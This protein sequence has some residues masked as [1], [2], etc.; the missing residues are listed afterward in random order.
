MVRLY[1]VALVAVAL[2]ACQ[3]DL[4][5][6]PWPPTWPW[7]AAPTA[8]PQVSALSILGP[9]GRAAENQHIQDQ[10]AAFERANPGLRLSGALTPDY[11]TALADAVAAHTPPD[12]FVVWS[13][14]LADLAADD[15]V[16]PIPP[17][18]DRTA[19]LPDPLRPA[20]QV[21]GVP[22]CLPRDLST[23]ALFF[24]PAL[25]DRAEAAYPT[26]L[27]TWDDLRRAATATTDANN[28]IYGLT[29]APDASRLLAWLA[30]DD[31][32]GDPWRGADAVSTLNNYVNLFAEGAAVDPLLLDSTWTGEAFGRGRAAMTLEANWLIPYLAEQ[33]PDLVYNIVELPSGTSRRSTVAFG[34]CWAISRT[35]AD[36]QAALR[37]AAFLT[38]PDAN[39][40]WA[41]AAGALPPAPDQGRAWLTGQPA[42]APFVAGLDY[43]LPWAGPRGFSTTMDSLNS[44]LAAAAI[45]DATAADVVARLDPS[46]TP[47]PTHTTPE[48]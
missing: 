30:A 27:W 37:L 22:Y 29:L 8:T 4:P 41:T 35:A 42:Y 32:D 17:A 46:A 20:F 25:F 6:P 19:S 11:R 18:Y 48:D 12:L 43:A 16:R 40:G 7:R 2:T 24:N 5:S 44:L 39:R 36:P 3:G 23:L 26:P 33:F 28:G 14:E 15:I 21:D 1:L 47:A 13:H 9:A 38:T 31:R 10:I 45:G 34:S